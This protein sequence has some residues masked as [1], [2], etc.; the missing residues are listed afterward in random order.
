MKLSPFVCTLFLAALVANAE[1]KPAA[2]TSPLRKDR[3]KWAAISYLGN[4]CGTLSP[5]QSKSLEEEH[6]ILI[7]A[8]PAVIPALIELISDERRSPPWF[9]GNAATYAI[10]YPFSEPLRA[11][12]RARRADK[13]FDPSGGCIIPLFE[14]FV[15]FGDK[16]DLAWMESAANRSDESALSASLIKKLRE[17]LSSK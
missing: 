7:D 2:D 6:R 10:Q 5:A 16:S 3:I 8:G 14:Y 11:A 4:E 17:R 13:N 1:D 9:V 15:V 12:L